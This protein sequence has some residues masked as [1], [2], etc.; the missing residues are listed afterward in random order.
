[1]DFFQYSQFSGFNIFAVLD[2]I[3][4]TLFH[5]GYRYHKNCS[6]GGRIHW[7]C[8]TYKHTKCKGR[9]STCLIN[10]YV[11]M[12]DTQPSHNHDPDGKYLWKRLTTYI[13]VAL[14]R[15]QKLWFNKY[16]LI[17]SQI[18]WIFFSILMLM[19]TCLKL[20]FFRSWKQT[21]CHK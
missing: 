15:V 18:T 10:G 17:Q 6:N 8:I 21:H 3:G 11:M 2:G 13:N 7:K 5:N 1:M 19:I 12:R 4:R 9:V 14:L 20:E 16:Y